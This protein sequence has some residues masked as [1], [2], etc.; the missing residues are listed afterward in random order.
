MTFNRT[1]PVIAIIGGLAVPALGLGLGRGRTVTYDM[2]F[3]GTELI[4]NADIL[5]P[6]RAP[7]PSG[8]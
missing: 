3:S 2:T 1:W 6:T 8:T 7:I 4:G 5:F